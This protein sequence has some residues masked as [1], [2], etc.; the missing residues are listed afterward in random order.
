MIYDTFWYWIDTWC[1]W[2]F[3]TYSGGRND[4]LSRV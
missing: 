3:E 2:W 1:D 4:D